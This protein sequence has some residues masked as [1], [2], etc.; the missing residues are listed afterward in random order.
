MSRCS[1]KEDI[2]MFAIRNM[3]V[4]RHGTRPCQSDTDIGDS[5]EMRHSIGFGNQRFPLSGNRFGYACDIGVSRD[6]TSSDTRN[7]RY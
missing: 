6:G 2:G 7:E 3:G 5:D 1:G 4:L